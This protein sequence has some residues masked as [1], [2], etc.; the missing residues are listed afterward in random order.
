[1][2]DVVQAV[3]ASRP[4]AMSDHRLQRL[5]PWAP[6]GVVLAVWAG[7]TAAAGWF[8]ATYGRNCPYGDE[9]DI[10][11]RVTGDRPFTM[12]WLFGP[13]NEH[14][15]VLP[16]LVQLLAVR[17]FGMDFRA[18][19]FLNVG[20]LAGLSLGLILVIWKLRG[21]ARYVDAFFPLALLHLGHW[22]NM[23]SGWQIQFT[24]P[25]ALFVL[26]ATLVSL[27][28]PRISTATAI[29]L[30][31]GLV[32][33][34]LSGA[35]GLI[36]VPALGV[37]LAGLAVSEWRVGQ[38]APA[39]ILL[40]GL[41]ATGILAVACRPEPSTAM[42]TGVHHLT[43]NAMALLSLAF[44]PPFCP[45]WAIA[46]ASTVGVAASFLVLI[47]S[48]GRGRRNGSAA[49]W[50]ALCLFATPLFLCAVAAAGWTPSLLVMPEAMNGE[51]VLRL[52][53]VWACAGVALTL[54]AGATVLEA[55]RSTSEQRRWQALALGAC[56]ASALALVAALA[57]ARSLPFDV[58]SLHPEAGD[59]RTSR[60]ML[61]LSILPIGALLAFDR[62][63]AGHRF[64]AA[65]LAWFALLSALSC[66][67][68]AVQQAADRARRL[69]A[70][71]KDVRA[72]LP[73]E[74]IAR[75]HAAAVF[76]AVDGES[77]IVELVTD[78]RRAQHPS[79]VSR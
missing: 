37:L 34:A 38:R 19:A 25:V 78:L 62:L 18:G 79:F 64:G 66:A 21:N 61:L 11:A 5:S 27:R 8:V 39:T 7:M 70:F 76:R 24:L 47:A 13:H 33:L 16:R 57:W 53:P 9:W 74:V 22:E 42:D 52:W 71:L 10:V 23:L 44:A 43:A 73:A 77:E 45:L 20:I 72:G 15:I 17:L 41:L 12:S 28:A 2:T 55:A 49:A 58:D 60:Y 63:G 67:P 40:A 75:K 4:V 35:N 14:R 59:V 56:L 1:M 30:A 31:I 69:D 46:A 54:F 3:A 6:A 50:C 48:A 29:V 26:V 36:L 51:R 32:G 68:A 65:L